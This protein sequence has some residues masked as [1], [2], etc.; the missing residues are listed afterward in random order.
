M[1]QAEVRL[2]CKALGFDPP[3]ATCHLRALAQGDTW[4]V[5][6]WSHEAPRRL[7]LSWLDAHG[8]FRS[9]DAPDAQPRILAVETD[10][11]PKAWRLLFE[12]L[13]TQSLRLRADGVAELVIRA[14]RDRVRQLLEETTDTEDARQLR[15]I[16][17][18]PED[19]EVPGVLTPEQHTALMAAFEAGYFDVPRG[20]Q[21]ETLAKRL[22]TSAGALSELLRRAQRRLVE[23]HLLGEQAPPNLVSSETPSGSRGDARTS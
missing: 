16:T 10:A 22:D 6:V 12:E 9:H 1:V 8:T 14:P 20:V 7:F 2:P 5:Y 21:L 19:K 3:P 17:S 4:I 11:L 18:S 23:R 13:D 15:S